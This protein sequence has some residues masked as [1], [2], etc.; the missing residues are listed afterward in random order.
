M[1]FSKIKEN[2]LK[3]L[4]YLDNQV[5]SNTEILLNECLKE[6]EQVTPKFMYQIYTL[7]HH[8]LTIKELNL[9]INYP[10]LIDLFD[11]CDRIVIIACTLGLQLD[12][13]LR[14]YSK[15]N[16]TKMTVMDALASSYIEI[17]CDEYE[18][19]Q[20]F[21][22]RTFRFCPGYGNVPLELNKNLANALNCSKHIG[23]TVQESN[24]LLPQKSMIGLIGLGDNRKEKTCQNCLHI[25]DCN[26]R[27][28]GQ[29]CYAK[30]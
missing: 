21:G 16:L 4:G 9:T 6:L 28:R 3:Y 1:N 23:L 13:Q 8:P 18:A 11:S 24:I 10:D 26:F 14:Y 19:K 5:D 7:T 2:A 20:N 25:K 27:K 12:Q 22:K 17:K 30:D 15:I 29:T